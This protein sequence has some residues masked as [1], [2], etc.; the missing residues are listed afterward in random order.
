M[1]YLVGRTLY[2]RAYV[3]DPP[4]RHIGFLLT[5]ILTCTLFALAFVGAR[6]PR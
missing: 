4:K 1:V 3:A 6:L 5:V 2:W